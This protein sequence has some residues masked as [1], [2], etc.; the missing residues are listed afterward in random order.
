[1]TDIQGP[2]DLWILE[3]SYHPDQSVHLCPKILLQFLDGSPTIQK[4]IT[5]A[6]VLSV[7]SYVTIVVLIGLAK[8]LFNCLTYSSTSSTY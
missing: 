2:S 7:D 3:C 1:M 4:G 5:V 6:G 8:P